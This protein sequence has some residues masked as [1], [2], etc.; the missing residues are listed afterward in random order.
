M[1]LEEICWE[2]DSSLR[3]LPPVLNSSETPQEVLI[4]KLVA[5]FGGLIFPEIHL[6]LPAG[7]HLNLGGYPKPVGNYLDDLD[8]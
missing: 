7:A 5:H 4:S 8:I 2:L 1:S 3:L 6:Q